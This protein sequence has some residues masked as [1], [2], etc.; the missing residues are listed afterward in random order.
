MNKLS[1]RRFTRLAVGGT[2][3]SLVNACGVGKQLQPGGTRSAPDLGTLPSPSP[4][5]VQAVSPTSARPILRNDNVPGFFVRYYKPFEAVDPDRW[6][7]TVDG[8]VQNPLSLS[9]SDVLEL[10]R[11][12]QVSRMKCVECWSAAARWEGF[13]LSSLLEIANPY[14]DA[15]WVHFGC[16]DGYYESMSIEG[17]LE[18]RVIFVHHMNDAIL[19]DIYGAPLR[20]MV[21]FLYGYKSAKAIVRL[22]F[23]KEELPGYWPTV[24][25]YTEQGTIRPGSDHPLDLEGSRQIAGGGE[26]V[27][28][29]GI[30]S[31]AHE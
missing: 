4:S 21:P 5:P 22:E 17:L 15:K 7:L 8:L 30:E 23:A 11:V 19:P 18:E 13:H 24:G 25:P 26:I 20:L 6:T 3:L 16:A 29:D 1:R 28:P 2:L 9:L 12:S 31:Q 27:Y 10:P 14:P